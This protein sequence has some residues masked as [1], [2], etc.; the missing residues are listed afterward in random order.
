MV[1]VSEELF[2]HFDR[3]ADEV[4]RTAAV[5]AERV[6]AQ[7]TDAEPTFVAEDREFVLV[8]YEMTK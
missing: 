7:L 6:G 5:A 8:Q 1:S 2:E 3:Y 4:R